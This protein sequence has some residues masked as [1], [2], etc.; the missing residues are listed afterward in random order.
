MGRRIITTVVTAADSYALASLADVKTELG[1]TDTSADTLLTRYL[2]GTSA[3]I[4]NYCNRKFVVE[5]VKDEIWPDREWYSFQVMGQLS[6][7]Q[8]TRWPVGTI[9]AITENGDDLVDGTDYRVDYDSGILTRLDGNL[10]PKPW[11]AWPVSVTYTAGFATIPYDVADAAIRMTKARYLSQ[12]RDPFL[13]QENIPGVREY[14]LWVPTGK[15]AGNMTPDVEDL[16]ENYR[17]PLVL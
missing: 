14:S 5:T 6:D 10:Y 4:A 11:L 1:I 7:L 3:A 8:L 2:N 16:L 13:K 15:D 17:L 9:S 12:G